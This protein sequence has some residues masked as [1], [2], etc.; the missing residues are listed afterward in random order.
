MLQPRKNKVGVFLIFMLIFLFYVY[1]YGEYVSKQLNTN[2][3]GPFVFQN[4]GRSPIII[5]AWTKF[6]GRSGFPDE[7]YAY[8]R[9]SSDCVVSSSRCYTNDADALVFHW[10]DLSIFD[11]PKK[12]EDQTWVLYNQESPEHLSFF[13][14]QYLRAINDYIDWTL[15]YRQDSDI[16]APYGYFI[17]R[18]NSSVSDNVTNNYESSYRTKKKSISWFVSNCRT[19]SHREAFVEQLQKY[20]DVDIFGECGQNV[21]PRSQTHKCDKLIEQ[22]YF[23]Y[24]SFENS[25]CK[26]YVTEKLFRIM[27]HNIVPITF[28]GAD[29]A[30]LLPASSYI[31]ALNFSS[32]E[33]LANFLKQ[34]S[35]NRDQYK[36]YLTWKQNYLVK[37]DDIQICLLCD[38]L[39]HKRNNDQNIV[40][41]NKRNLI[42]WWFDAN[43]T[44]WE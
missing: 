21:C 16:V 44:Y 19:P 29:Y 37:T 22:D 17:E 39:R 32:V 9:C 25:L 31:D 27:K 2:C 6:F 18:N 43:C 20:I 30:K 4:S 5:L 12:Q 38:K 24:L 7:N 35:S 40:A 28:G 11:L 26:D 15:T 13:R 14:T 42:N 10:R 34:V 41:S 33:Q 1:K 23:F 36:S 3:R 8:Y